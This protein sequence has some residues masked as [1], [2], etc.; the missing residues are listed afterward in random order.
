MALSRA[1]ALS[2][3]RR[4]EAADDLRASLTMSIRSPSSQIQRAVGHDALAGLE[5]FGERDGFRAR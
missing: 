2:P 3:G 5:A 4:L 1:C